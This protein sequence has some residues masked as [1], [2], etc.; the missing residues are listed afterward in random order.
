MKWGALLVGGAFSGILFLLATRL[1]LNLSQFRDL[2]PATLE[3]LKR[4]P[5]RNASAARYGFGA[6]LPR[7]D[8]TMDRIQFEI[9]P[10]GNPFS[11][12]FLFATGEGDM[13]FV[14]IIDEDGSFL[15]GP[16]LATLDF[17]F[18]NAVRGRIRGPALVNGR[19][20]IYA[21][22]EGVCWE[23]KRRDYRPVPAYRWAGPIVS[24]ARPYGG[25]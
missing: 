25:R 4:A 22:L 23:E 21:M 19:P 18:F 1:A 3:G 16:H 17:P 2:E 24:D 20:T 11:V 14:G 15:C 8:G 13:A 10:G 7:T 6:K 5:F 9:K 12:T